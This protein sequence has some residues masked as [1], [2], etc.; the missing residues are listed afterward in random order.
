L[1]DNDAIR[2]RL[3][4]TDTVFRRDGLVEIR[5]GEQGVC[6]YGQIANQTAGS[7][8][9]TL[10][11]TPC[12][13]YVLSTGNEAEIV[14]S[15]GGALY[16]A[17]VIFT[18]WSNGQLSL[19]YRTESR[20]AP[21]RTKSRIR[22]E[23]TVQYRAVRPDGRMG[24]WLECTA[25]DVSCGGIGLIFEPGIP[26]PR[27]IQ[28]KFV[29]PPVSSLSGSKQ[30]DDSVAVIRGFYDE[31]PIKAAGRVVHTQPRT[32]SKIHAGVAYTVITS[33]E[34]DRIARFIESLAVHAA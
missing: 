7:L 24:A 30:E 27:R 29:L 14:Y 2:F 22:C 5:L 6:L 3:R 17:V 25:E 8:T 1:F 11:T 23:M 10:I 19:E 21:R 12:D 31:P 34:R 15:A 18:G 16:T 33:Q 26:I 13:S 20:P 9:V 32:E 4:S 28:V